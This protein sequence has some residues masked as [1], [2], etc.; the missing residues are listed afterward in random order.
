MRRRPDSISET[1]ERMEREYLAE[2]L[3]QAAGV[4]VQRRPNGR[5]QLPAVPLSAKKYNLK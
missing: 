5:S 3:K 4:K 2:A 1:R